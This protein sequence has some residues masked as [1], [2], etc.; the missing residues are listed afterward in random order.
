MNR[1]GKKM[2]T[3]QPNRKKIVA[4]FKPKLT[5]HELL[6]LDNLVQG[7]FVCR[8]SKHN[9]SPFVGDVLVNGEQWEGVLS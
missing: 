2:A 6:R 4:K 5:S 7:E 1:C 9:K 8:P 3:E